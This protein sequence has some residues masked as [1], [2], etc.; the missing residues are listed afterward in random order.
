M[1]EAPPAGRPRD[2]RIDEAVLAAARDLVAELGY[3]D[4]TFRAIAERAG[5]SVP[6][7]RRRWASK[8]HLVHEAVYPADAVAAPTGAADLRAEVRAVVERCLEIVGSPAGRRATPALMSELMA[9]HAL[10]EELSSRLLSAGWDTLAA[11]L[12]EAA[13]RGEARPDVDLGLFIEMVFGTTLVAIVLRGRAA[14]DDA[15]V[16]EVVRSIVDGLAAR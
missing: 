3:A 13:A 15:W 8:A 11:R 16:D 12:A 10:E 9:D 5:T 4:L 7:I 2:V 6:A 1:S 14:V